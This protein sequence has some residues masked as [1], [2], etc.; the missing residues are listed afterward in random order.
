MLIIG[1]HNVLPGVPT[2]EGVRHAF[3]CADRAKRFIA[4][5]EAQGDRGGDAAKLRHDLR[6]SLGTLRCALEVLTLSPSASDLVM[7]S[8]AI[9]LRHAAQLELKMS[10]HGGSQ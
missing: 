7:E 6:S 1:D 5:L 3:A 9:A 4:T 10:G 2:D 8:K